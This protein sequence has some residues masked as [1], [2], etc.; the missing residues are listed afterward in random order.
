[1]RVVLYTSRRVSVLRVITV[2][3][4]LNHCR[5]AA[6][7]ITNRLAKGSCISRDRFESNNDETVRERERDIFRYFSDEIVNFGEKRERRNGRAEFE[8]RRPSLQV[9]KLRLDTRRRDPI[10][11]SRLDSIQAHPAWKLRR[12]RH[13]WNFENSLSLSLSPSTSTCRV[14][15]ARTASRT[16]GSSRVGWL[17][18]RVSR[19]RSISVLSPRMMMD[20]GLFRRGNNLPFF[21]FPPLCPPPRIR[22]R[23]L[24]NSKVTK[25]RGDG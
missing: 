20:R 24:L 7:Q 9:A 5:L 11:P 6:R 18:C 8:I 10:D 2:E 19:D 13:L 4:K 23:D 15:I 16:I 17:S 1:M 14:Q 3:R 21:F 22:P 25:E 12:T